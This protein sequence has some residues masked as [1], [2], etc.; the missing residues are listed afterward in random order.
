MKITIAFIGITTFYM[1]KGSLR[2]FGKT[3]RMARS[4]PFHMEKMIHIGNPPLGC[5]GVVTIY[6][7][8]PACPNGRG[9]YIYNIVEK[10]GSADSGFTAII[11]SVRQ[12]MQLLHKCPDFVFIKS[13]E[14]ARPVIFIAQPQMITE[15]WL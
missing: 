6:P 10:I 1:T 3:T 5:I 4:P 14:V 2:V 11:K 9:I 12:I 15:G 8:V 7:P 13:I